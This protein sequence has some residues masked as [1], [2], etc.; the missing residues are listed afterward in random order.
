MSKVIPEPVLKESPITWVYH[1]PCQSRL[2]AL[3]IQKDG[4]LLVAAGLAGL[5]GRGTTFYLTDER[6]S[7]R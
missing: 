1:L 2:S 3:P 5:A 7:Y 6:E 4:L